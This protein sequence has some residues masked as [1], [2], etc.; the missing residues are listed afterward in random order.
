MIR[1]SRPQPV[2]PAPTEL[3]LVTRMGDNTSPILLTDVP[4]EIA[5]FNRPFELS[6]LVGNLD[7]VMYLAYGAAENVTCVSDVEEGETKYFLAYDNGEA[8]I[9]ELSVEG[10]TLLCSEKGNENYLFD[11]DFKHQNRKFFEQANGTYAVALPSL[12]KSAGTKAIVSVSSEPSGKSVNIH[13]ENGTYNAWCDVAGNIVTTPWFATIQ[14]LSQLNNIVTLVDKIIKLEYSSE[15]AGGITV[16]SASTQPTTV[17]GNWNLFT[18]GEPFIP[19]S[20]VSRLSA[21]C[22]ILP[23]AYEDVPEHRVPVCQ[24]NRVPLPGELEDVLKFVLQDGSE[25]STN[26]VGYNSEYNAYFVNY[27]GG[28]LNLLLNGVTLYATDDADVPVVWDVDFDHQFRRSLPAEF[29]K[30]N[31]QIPQLLYNPSAGQGIGIMHDAEG[32]PN[33]GVCTAQDNAPY[34]IDGNTWSS[35]KGTWANDLTW[36]NV[37]SL[38]QAIIAMEFEGFDVEPPFIDPVDYR[39][40]LATGFVVT[41]LIPQTLS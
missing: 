11:L 37:Q 33:F 9:G 18:D 36:A 14:D 31:V 34:I 29:V 15:A 28:T 35:E 32:Q 7:G 17:S 40:A 25:V 1:G 27:S 39:E 5:T 24:F 23:E 13:Y 8:H 30:M 12:T 22:P 19:L 26:A 6:E 41:P 10:T 2:P 16:S 38:L 3:L 20:I 21:A 4:Q